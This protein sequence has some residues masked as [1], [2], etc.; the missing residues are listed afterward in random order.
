MSTRNTR[1]EQRPPRREPVPKRRLDGSVGK[2]K[3]TQQDADD[4]KA[5]CD[6]A[7]ISSRMDELSALASK[8]R[9]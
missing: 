3:P 2:F 9:V 7:P 8:A 4:L 1:M 5:F 6:E